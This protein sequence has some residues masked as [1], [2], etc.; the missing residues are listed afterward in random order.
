MV[1]LRLNSDSSMRVLVEVWDRSPGAPIA[2]QVGPDEEHGRGLM[3]VEALTERWN[4]SCVQGWRGKS[5]AGSLYLEKL[6]E[7]ERYQAMFNHLVAK[8]L[9]QGSGVFLTHP[10]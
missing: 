7:V 3:L 1:Y 10:V 4:W 5:Q 6:S 9:D 8:A 2:K